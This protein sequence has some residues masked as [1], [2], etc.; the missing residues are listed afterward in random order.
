MCFFPLPPES[1]F[2]LSTPPAYVQTPP[3]CLIAGAAC[4][5]PGSSCWHWTGQSCI[6]GPELEVLP[7]APLFLSRNCSGSPSYSLPPTS[8]HAKPSQRSMY[9]GCQHTPAKVLCY[10]AFS[11]A[12]NRM[13]G[14]ACA[15][16]AFEMCTSGQRPGSWMASGSALPPAST[17]A[18]QSC[19]C[20]RL[21]ATGRCMF[22]RLTASKHAQRHMDPALDNACR[23][24]DGHACIQQSIFAHA[25]ACACLVIDMH[26]GM[27]MGMHAPD[28]GN[29]SATT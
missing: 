19:R 8:L 10:A 1:T 9:L 17:S 3:K 24:V 11:D 6:R 5:D 26:A 29:D 27:C 22:A 14:F 16:W 12:G 25:H 23:H 28:T 7:A 2:V 15:G 4:T 13:V 20:A 21:S 18:S